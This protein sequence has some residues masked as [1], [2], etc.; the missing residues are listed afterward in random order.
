MQ[1]NKR[2]EKKKRARRVEK[3]NTNGLGRKERVKSSSKEM[4]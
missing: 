2:I 4:Q 3:E 1:K